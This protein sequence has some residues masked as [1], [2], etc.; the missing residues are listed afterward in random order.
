MSDACSMQQ[1]GP[2]E[3]LNSTPLNIVAHIYHTI[4]FAHI[5]IKTRHRVSLTY[6]IVTIGT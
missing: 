4:Y 3:S 2:L 6:L 5:L 1:T